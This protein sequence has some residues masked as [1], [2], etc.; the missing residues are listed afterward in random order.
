MTIS[1]FIYCIDPLHGAGL[2]ALLRNQTDFEIVGETCDR[3][4]AARRVAELAVDLVVVSGFETDIE[5]CRELAAI[6]KVVTFANVETLGDAEKVLALNARA[7]LHPGISPSEL[8]FAIR[9]VA[10]DALV[11]LP[12]VMQSHL[13][14][15]AQQATRSGPPVSVGELT[16]RETD[17]LGLLSHGLSNQDVA[18]LLFL[19]A[20]TVRSHVH[21]ILRKMNVRNRT[22]AVALACRAGFTPNVVEFDQR[23]RER[24][25]G[26]TPADEDAGGAR[27]P[28]RPDSPYHQDD[29]VA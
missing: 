18:D 20:A 27:N 15:M 6:T 23:L 1:I 14:R 9:T 24:L 22:Q 3:R 12:V 16:S 13:Q 4:E 8:I 25:S 28:P 29:V 7:V 19:S 5:A 2:G 26:R 10:T 17:V 11:V 21:H